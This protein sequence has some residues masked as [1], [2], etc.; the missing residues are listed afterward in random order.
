MT[1]QQFIEEIRRL[2]VADRIALLEAITRSLREDLETRQEN[3]SVNKESRQSGTQSSGEDKVLLSQSLYGILK[4]DG[5][6]PT[7]EELKDGYADYL[8]E[9]YS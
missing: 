1:Q 5:D 7:D 8:M 9:K 4:F 6:P 2:S 3:I